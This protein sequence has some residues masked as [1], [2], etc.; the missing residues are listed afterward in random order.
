[1]H[2]E[3][4][5]P[6]SLRAPSRRS[7]SST[8]DEEGV[9][10]QTRRSPP[11]GSRPGSPHSSTDPKSVTEPRRAPFR[12]THSKAPRTRSKSRQSGPPPPLP[13]LSAP[14]PRAR[15]AGWVQRRR[16]PPSRI[17]NSRFKG[18]NERAVSSGLSATH[19]Y[20]VK[21]NFSQA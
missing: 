19:P 9:L 18:K 17:S 10:N 3:R 5:L 16:A 1:M 8:A 13:R 4:L 15:D 11:R 7:L 2:C 14:E 21:S 12:A 20:G 6:L